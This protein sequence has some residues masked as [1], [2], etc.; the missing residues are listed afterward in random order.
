MSISKGQ[1]D[2]LGGPGPGGVT[3]IIK[4]QFV[5]VPAPEGVQVLIKTYPEI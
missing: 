1:I 2:G 3:A 4:G 5:P